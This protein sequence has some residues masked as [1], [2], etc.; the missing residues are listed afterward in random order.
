MTNTPSRKTAGPA[1]MVTLFFI[2]MKLVDIFVLGDV[3][4]PVWSAASRIAVAAMIIFGMCYYVIGPEIDRAKQTRRVA[5][6]GLCRLAVGGAVVLLC[7][8]LA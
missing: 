7:F 5:L 8:V 6:G 2:A 3:R 1:L 4:G